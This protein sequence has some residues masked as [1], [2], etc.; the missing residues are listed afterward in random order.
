[1]PNIPYNVWYKTF[2]INL[3]NLPVGRI[4]W[5]MKPTGGDISGQK[6]RYPPPKAVQWPDR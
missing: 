4:N 1:M 2:G 5:G 6:R 3:N